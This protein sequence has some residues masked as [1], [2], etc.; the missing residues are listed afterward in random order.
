MLQ[1]SKRNTLE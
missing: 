1:L